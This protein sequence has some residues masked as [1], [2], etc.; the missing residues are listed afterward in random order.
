MLSFARKLVQCVPTSVATNIKE[1]VLKLLSLPT[2]NFLLELLSLRQQFGMD[3]VWVVVGI[4]VL[5]AVLIG[6]GVIMSH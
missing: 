4:L 2:S 3:E 1:L 5:H 6:L